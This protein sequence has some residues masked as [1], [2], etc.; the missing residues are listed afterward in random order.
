MQFSLFERHVGLQLLFYTPIFSSLIPALCQVWRCLLCCKLFTFDTFVRHIQSFFSPSTR[1]I[2]LAQFESRISPIIDSRVSGDC[3]NQLHGCPS[4][5]RPSIRSLSKRILS[6]PI[7]ML[8]SFPISAS[9][10]SLSSTVHTILP[11]SLKRGLL[12]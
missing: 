4:T 11:P 10:K 3:W 6:H 9:P 8:C 12:T 1:N 5:A 7:S 2:P